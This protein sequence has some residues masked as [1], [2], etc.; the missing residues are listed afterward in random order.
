[1]I[2]IK[3]HNLMDAVQWTNVQDFGFKQYNRSFYSE[4]KQ[5]IQ[6]SANGHESHSESSS[7]LKAEIESEKFNG[8]VDALN[9]KFWRTL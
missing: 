4:S 6:S 3:N 2:N 5:L 1:M 7:Q 9:Y 8:V